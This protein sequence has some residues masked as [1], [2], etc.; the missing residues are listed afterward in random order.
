MLLRYPRVWR[1]R[2]PTATDTRPGALALTCSTV[3]TGGRRT[4]GGK[5][6]G[7]P[8][9][10]RAFATFC[11]VLYSWLRAGSSGTRATI[12]AAAGSGGAAGR[13]CWLP[14]TPPR[15]LSSTRKRSLHNW[16]PGSMSTPSVRPPATAHLSRSLP[17]ASPRPGRR[18][19]GRPQPGRA[20]PVRS[21]DPDARPG[22]SRGAR[23]GW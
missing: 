19:T 5:P 12:A 14:L 18:A 15:Q 23:Q 22:Q 7:T 9:R 6:P 2:Q 20:R 16:M 21:S 17:C 11:R 10:T 8:P 4:N 3:A 1:L 13:T